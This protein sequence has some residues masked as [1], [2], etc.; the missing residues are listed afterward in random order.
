LEKGEERDNL[1]TL[2]VDGK[3]LLKWS[4]KE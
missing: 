4:V 3:I 1:E 2:R